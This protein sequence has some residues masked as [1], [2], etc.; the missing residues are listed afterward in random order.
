MGGSGIFNAVTSS[1]LIDTDDDLCKRMMQA[2]PTLSEYDEHHFKPKS[3]TNFN[4]MFH[5][6]LETRLYTK[7]EQ[8][9]AK[10][11]ESF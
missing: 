5:K 11:T 9:R 6:R 4:E 10:A 2:E 1:S 3:A 8:L 7:S